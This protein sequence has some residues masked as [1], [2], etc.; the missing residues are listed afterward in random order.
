MNKWKN[1][2]V[3]LGEVHA[4]SKSTIYFYLN[5]EVDIKTLKSSCGC[6][7]PEFDSAKQRIKVVY[8][9]GKLPAHLESQTVRT[10]VSVKYEDDSIDIL[11][12]N[13][14]KIKG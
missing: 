1:P 10:H 12:I 13:A 9:A 4:H 8:S 14:T 11:Y 6:T 2:S 3:Q 7:T 5:E